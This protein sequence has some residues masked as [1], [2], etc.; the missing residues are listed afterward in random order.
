VDTDTGEFSSAEIQLPQNLLPGVYELE[1]KVSIDFDKAKAIVQ[2][3]SQLQK[4]QSL[5]GLKITQDLAVSIGDTYF[6]YE[7]D[8]QFKVHIS[9]NA[10]L[11]CNRFSDDQKSVAF[12]SVVANSSSVNTITE[13]TVPKVLL[14]GQILVVID[15][16]PVSN[17]SVI[18]KN[19]SADEN[20]SMTVL[21][22]NYSAGAHTVEIYGTSVIPEFPLMSYMLL[23]VAITVIASGTVL[24]KMKLHSFR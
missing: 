6:V 11:C 4:L 13:V 19:M 9:S 5:E 8:G 12:E 22:I 14:G 20:G 10:N 21:E 18:I 24:R 23:G 15:G 2:D 3:D 7:E 1:A 17:D 16:Q